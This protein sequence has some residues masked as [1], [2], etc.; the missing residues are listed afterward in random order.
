MT[1]FVQL[2]HKQGQL[3]TQ[4]MLRTHLHSQIGRFRLWC[5]SVA[6][7]MSPFPTFDRRKSK[8]HRPAT[9]GVEQDTS[10]RTTLPLAR[11]LFPK[12]PILCQR[13]D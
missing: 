7:S 4:L 10:E 3:I 13:S 12:N 2:S 6:H 9:G 8:G 11:C 1:Y 5:K